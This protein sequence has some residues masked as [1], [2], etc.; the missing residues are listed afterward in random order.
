MS[1]FGR[2]VSLHVSFLQNCNRDVKNALEE[3]FK[4]MKWV[5]PFH[6]L[7]CRQF[8]F[9]I[10]SMTSPFY[11]PFIIQTCRE[12]LHL[13]KQVP[14]ASG[15]H[16]SLSH[17]TPSSST[18]QSAT[19]PRSSAAFSSTLATWTIPSYPFATG[20]YVDWWAEPVHMHSELL[21]HQPL[22]AAELQGLRRPLRN[23]S[24]EDREGASALHSERHRDP[25]SRHSP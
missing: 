2:L 19:T 21:H 12:T 7:I 13:C 3:Q 25:S 10:S 1:R 24:R 5:F 11:T 20:C 9:L 18:R 14:S 6:G 8:S 4:F 16:R 15:I 23:L 17:R 22:P